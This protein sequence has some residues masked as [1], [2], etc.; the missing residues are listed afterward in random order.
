[1]DGA[2]EGVNEIGE[3]TIVKLLNTNIITIIESNYDEVKKEYDKK[4][5][6]DYK[7]YLEIEKRR[8][9]TFYH[10]KDKKEKTEKETKEDAEN[11]ETEPL[12]LED[13]KQETHGFLYRLFHRT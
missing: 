1:M 10:S 6:E 3:T 11:V 9:E 2:F 13:E 7:K 8:R 12:K 4:C 5:S